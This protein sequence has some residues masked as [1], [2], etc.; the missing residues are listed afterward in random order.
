MRLFIFRL[1]RYII[2]VEGGGAM[3]VKEIGKNIRGLR[4]DLE[5]TQPQV[6]ERADITAVHLSHIETGNS[7]MSIDCLL[8]LCAALSTTPNDILMG[9]FELTGKAA[10]AML[11]GIMGDLTSDE[12]RLLLEIAESMHKLKVNRT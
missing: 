10:N 5:L 3:R 11:Q 2:I 6:A 9:E 4:T 8:R 7:T 12:N 1:V